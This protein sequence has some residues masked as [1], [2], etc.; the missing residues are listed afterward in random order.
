MRR[1]LLM[2]YWERLYLFSSSSSGRSCVLCLNFPDVPAWYSSINERAPA[3]TIAVRVVQLT[4]T[5][6]VESKMEEAKNLVA[7]QRP[8]GA[9][10]P[11]A[12]AAE[13]CRFSCI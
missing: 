13:V 6:R 10:A 2:S 7:G 12:V 9:S 4:H 3:C 5:R 1:Q 8:S 11:W